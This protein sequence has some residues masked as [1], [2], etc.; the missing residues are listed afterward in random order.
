MEETKR[1]SKQ[2]LS[3]KQIWLRRDLFDVVNSSRG[4]VPIQHHL[5]ALIESALRQRRILPPVTE[6]PAA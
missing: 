5:D 2:A 1:K 6:Q 3:R 4:A